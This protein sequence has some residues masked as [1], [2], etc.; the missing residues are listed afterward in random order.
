MN[1][2]S[3]ASENASSPI[4]GLPRVIIE[5]SESTT[6][7]DLEKVRSQL[8][9]RITE[10]KRGV[11]VDCI[12][13]QTVS[14]DGLLCLRMAQ[15]FA[16]NE[17]K[18]FIFYGTTKAFRSQLASHRSQFSFEVFGAKISDSNVEPAASRRPWFWQTQKGKRGL[19]IALPVLVALPIV[20]GAEYYYVMSASNDDT[21]VV[22]KSFEFGDA[23]RIAGVVVS[24]KADSGSRVDDNTRVFI[25]RRGLPQLGES[26]C[27]M[28][29]CNSRGEYTIDLP[30]SQQLPRVDVDITVVH[31]GS[32]VTHRRT[33]IN[34]R[35]EFVE[36][37]LSS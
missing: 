15:I 34:G 12:S 31:R 5:L 25:A 35:P 21:I 17:R 27:W 36:S 14:L 37:S 8:Y 33:L 7:K 26:N 10:S 16:A 19:R 32:S 18:R 4:L 24:S 1:R 23:F 3:Q 30:V 22:K 13:I 20:F 9:Q 29:R 28:V 11:V 2:S 6:G